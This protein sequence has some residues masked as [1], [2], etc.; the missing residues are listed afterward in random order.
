VRRILGA[1]ILAGMAVTIGACVARA[2]VNVIAPALEFWCPMHPAVRSA[3]AGRCPICQMELVRASSGVGDTYRLDVELTPA[4]PQPGE[5]TRARF[6][7]RD[8]HGGATVTRFDVL[9]EKLFHLFVVSRD[10]QYFAHL[11]PEFG[12]GGAFDVDLA[13]PQPGHYQLL[14]DLVPTGAAPQLIERAITTAGFEGPL[15]AVPS[16][17]AD[18]TDKVIG[19]T[20]VHLSMREAMAGGDRLMNFELFDAVTGVPVADLEPFLGAPGHLLV[21]SADLSYASHSHPL[22]EEGPASSVAFQVL[23]AR[24]GMHKVWV[25]FQ[26][27]G[28]VLTVPFTIPVEERQRTGT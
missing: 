2:P 6:H 26:R 3:V 27:S 4:A 9:H 17:P 13:L 18:L 5:V 15:H 24:A 19:N 22:A 10:L 25:Q 7:V 20:R 12:A 23:F 8:P 14:A 16:L 1:A 28:R 21:V 11:H